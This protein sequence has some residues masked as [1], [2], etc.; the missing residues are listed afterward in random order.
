MTGL[1]GRN[2][3]VVTYDLDGLTAICRELYVL[4]A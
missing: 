3:V 1:S 2:T 4:A